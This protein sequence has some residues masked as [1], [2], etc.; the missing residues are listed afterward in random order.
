MTDEELLARIN[1]ILKPLGCI[2]TEM[3]P[4]SVGVQGD[5]RFY[6]PCVFVTIPP[7]VKPEEW[8]AIATRIINEVP[9]VSRVLKNITPC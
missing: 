4:D 6:G 9:G 2:A 8:G 7:E 1:V 5:K 3:G